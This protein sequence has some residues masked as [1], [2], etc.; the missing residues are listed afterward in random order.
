MFQPLGNLLGDSVRRAKIAPEIEATYAMQ[1]FSDAAVGVWGTSISEQIKPMYLKNRC[2]TVAVLS[3]IFVQEIRL[4]EKQLIDAI[5]EK[6]K[7]TVVEKIKC[8]I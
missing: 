8:L 3:N 7:K 6:M 2:L 1:C 4:R 5:N